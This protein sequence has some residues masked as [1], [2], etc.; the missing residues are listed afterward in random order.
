MLHKDLLHV[1]RHELA[2]V[3]RIPQLAGYAEIFAAASEGGG[4]AAFDGGGNA[5]WNEE[6][7][8]AASDGD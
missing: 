5:F 3:S 1:L 2:N 8:F 7:L 4:F 6:I